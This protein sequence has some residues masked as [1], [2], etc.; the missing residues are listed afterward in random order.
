[1]KKSIAHAPPR[2]ATRLLEWYCKKRLLEDLQGDLNEYFHRNV[3]E[4]GLWRARLIYTLDVFK[5]FR[6]YTIRKP[7]LIDFMIHTVMLSSY[8]KTSGRSIFR[9][10]FFSSVN[11]IGLAISMSVG[12]LMIA[13]LDDIY[14]YDKFH[15]KHDRIYRVISLYEYMGRQDNDF[16]AST[17]MKAALAIRETISGPE[18]VAI[19]RRNFS[20]DANFEG[21]TVALR[22][23]YADESFFDIFSFTLLHGNPS[24]A[25]KAPFSVVLTV[26]SAM[27]LFNDVNVLGKTISLDSAHQFTVTGIAENVPKFSHM[28]F[29][30]L[31][32][33]STR[34]ITEKH[35]MEEE[36]QWD[37][38]WETYVYVLLPNGSDP[39]ILQQNLNQLSKTEDKTVKDTHIKLAL[40]PMDNI[41]GGHNL[42]NQLG[43]IIGKTTVSVF[44]ILAFLVILCAC[45][46]YT[47]L[48]IARAFKRSREI[49]VRKTIGARRGHVVAQFLV[50]SVI[51]A[52]LALLLSILLFLLVRPHFIGMED[53]LKELLT[54]EL[55]SSLIIAFVIFSIFVG[56]AA[57]LFPAFFFSRLNPLQVLKNLS[58][59]N[60][61]RGLGL[62]KTL[63]VV[64]Y[65]FSIMLITGTIILYKQYKHFLAY[66]LGFTTE[67]ILNIRLQGNKADL[68]TKELNE[69]PEVRD[70]S[71]S[72]AV[73][74]IGNYY[75]AN[76]KNP[77]TPEDSLGEAINFNG[78][79]E[80]YLSLHNFRLI[81][82][83][84]F[85]PKADQAVETEV[86][87]NKSFLKRFNIV[88]DNPA[89]ALGETVL[90]NGLPVKIVG[91]IEDFQ[92]G[93]AN[94]RHRSRAV[95]FR[96]AAGDP[97][98]LNVKLESYDWLSTRQKIAAIWRRLDD[99]HALDAKF[100]DD[101]IEDAFQGL[102]ASAR[103][104]GF[105]AFLL[106]CL[107]SI[108]LLG[109]VVYATE[110]R[111]K[112][113]SIRKVF[114][115]SN[116]GI[117]YLLGK[118]F[119][120]LLGIAAAIAVPLTYFAFDKIM[121]PEI[122][123]HAP[124]GIFE[125]FG[126]L[127]GIAIIA[128]LMIG[129]QMTKVIHT[130]PGEVLKNE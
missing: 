13:M 2:W 37:N 127:A 67:N 72:N 31:G 55:S 76:V 43:P 18:D 126:G 44:L 69:L 34:Q 124:L 23:M 47:N 40:Q 65:T 49:G 103:L 94:D 129:S 110:T 26:E 25:L 6:S 85:I 95:M 78:I 54:L 63:I 59:K 112:E 88:P 36:M 84:N 115:A 8:F 71:R 79:D 21:K 29:D 64:Q 87:V 90:L 77:L 9:N 28:K 48:S 42:S 107:A 33:I 56:L 86:I 121:L 38:M 60:L 14:S 68:F 116:A 30:M 96:Y 125:F 7:E 113:I 19:L 57:G 104:S 4:K 123:N 10:K 70:I 82:G 74:S 81:E 99:V 3:N 73:M 109:M 117:F 119:F 92:Y 51:I 20:G 101:Q 120:L 111:L 62:R 45:F 130:N 50:E 32:S 83:R 93:R 58:A 27:K 97:T 15:E 128:M 53:S 22:G 35:R 16:H 122:A 118:G 12:L 91:V 11:I 106:I 108:G 75:I 61:I 98:Y 5:F 46:N 114:G 1:M 105:I 102:A 80:N 66:D 17:S 41:I 100:Y 89:K 52:V 24:T 39:D